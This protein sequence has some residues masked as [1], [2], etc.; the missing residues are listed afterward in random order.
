MRCMMAPRLRIVTTT[1]IIIKSTID[2]NSTIPLPAP[3]PSWCSIPTLHQHRQERFCI[4]RP[5]EHQVPPLPRRTKSSPCHPWSTRRC[6]A[7]TRTR[8]FSAQYH[9]N[10]QGRLV[11]RLLRVRMPHIFPLQRA[12]ILTT[13]TISISTWDP[14][15]VLPCTRHTII[16]SFLELVSIR[17]TTTPVRHPRGGQESDHHD[18]NR[19][20]EKN[21]TFIII[22]VTTLLPWKE[23][24]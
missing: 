4:Q 19:N 22:A 2:I 9:P 8:P 3:A 15:V 20:T 24:R 12:R 17:I 6:C 23:L 18:G 7:S 14:R 11:R 21:A 13:S 1:T 16:R 10:R 5:Q